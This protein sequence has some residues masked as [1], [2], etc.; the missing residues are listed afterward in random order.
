MR[1][2]GVVWKLFYFYSSLWAS[3]TSIFRG[4]PFAVLQ[5]NRLASSPNWLGSFGSVSLCIE[6]V[7][8]LYLVPTLEGRNPL[9]SIV[10]F[11]LLLIYFY[12]I[13]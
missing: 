10:L 8:S 3:C 1:S 2:E 7:S 6:G 4:V 12:C 9:P 13:S 11:A 5:L